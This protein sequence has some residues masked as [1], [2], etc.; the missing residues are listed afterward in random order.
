[1]LKVNILP[2]RNEMNSPVDMN[3]DGKTPRVPRILG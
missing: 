1:M 2:K 3:I